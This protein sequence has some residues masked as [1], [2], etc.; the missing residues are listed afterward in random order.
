MCLFAVLLQ[1]D[2]AQAAQSPQPAEYANRVAVS[3]PVP[4]LNAQD[5]P[6][7]LPT[8][9]SH[10]NYEKLLFP[11]IKSRA[12]A[13]QLGWGHDKYVRDTGAYVKGKYYGTHPAVRCFYSPKVMYWLTGE[14]DFWPEGR[15]TGVAPHKKPREG[16]IPDGGMIIKEMLPPPAARYEGMTEEE[17]LAVLTLPT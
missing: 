9:M 8:T 12:Y 7:P 14:P 13:T 16:V 15:D 3:K 17:I 11:F 1:S 2:L 6:L 4:G 5:H 10:I